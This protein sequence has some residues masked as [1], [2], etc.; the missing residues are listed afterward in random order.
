[1][2][3]QKTQHA[4]Y[5]ELTA[6]GRL[7]EYWASHLDSALDQTIRS[8]A[9]NIRL[10]LAAVTYLS[11][12]G[13]RILLQH[14]K[15]LNEI[16]GS[17]AV[18]DPSPFVRKILDM[19]RLSPLLIVDKPAAKAPAAEPAKPAARRLERESGAFDVLDYVPGASLQCRVIGDPA[20]IEQCRFGEEQARKVAFPETALGLGLG[21]FGSDFQDCRNR[22]GEFLAV[23]GAAVYLPT[24][25][26]NVPDYMLSAGSF[27]PEVNVLYGL[28]C[29]GQFAT[30]ARFEG[31]KDT[32]GIKLSDAVETCLEIA[33]ADAAVVVMVAEAA[34]LV[35]AALRRSPAREQAMAGAAPFAHPE[36]R[37]WISFTAEPAYAGSVCLV[38]GIATRA[39]NPHLDP[40]LRPLGKGAQPAG[41]FHAAAFH[42][43]PIQKGDIDL[44]TTV[45]TLFDT[46]NLLGILHLLADRREAA[47]AGETEL[48]RGACWISPVSSVV[49]EDA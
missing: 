25:G 15:Q 16:H 42:Y 28:A 49:R 33:G 27:V 9:H 2:E 18:T 6:T 13:I 17:F 11:S 5:V 20:R 32:R 45:K 41:H 43:R 37:N 48:I 40:M 26:S 34:G 36:I 46:Q 23:A 35:G 12:A 14:Y 24:D 4:D 10:N 3:I 1:M 19:T 44:R 8:G 22:F 47:G 31:A 38:A 7:D 29:E 39:P 21:A 30:L